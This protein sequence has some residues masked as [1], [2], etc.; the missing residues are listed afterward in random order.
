M[1]GHAFGGGYNPEQWDRAVWDEDIALMR[2]AG[3]NLAPLAVAVLASQV[4]APPV[5]AP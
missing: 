3:V 4:K 1:G 5:S 2:E